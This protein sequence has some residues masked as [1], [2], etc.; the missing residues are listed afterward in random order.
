MQ[1]YVLFDQQQQKLIGIL[2][3]QFY[4]VDKRLVLGAINP[5]VQSQSTLIEQIIIT[6]L[7]DDIQKWR[8]WVFDNV[9]NLEVI[10]SEQHS[11]ALKDV[12][13]KQLDVSS[14]PLLQYRDA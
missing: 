14:A 11:F 1:L 2:K 12:A 8:R 9:N 5:S 7:V 6:G 13:I 3:K 10:V 4:D